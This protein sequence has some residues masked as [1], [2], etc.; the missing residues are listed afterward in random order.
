MKW[1]LLVFSF[2][3]NF[4]IPGNIM[5]HLCFYLLVV[6]HTCVLCLTSPFRFPG[7]SPF[8]SKSEIHI[9]K[10]KVKVFLYSFEYWVNCIKSPLSTIFYIWM[11]RKVN[12]IIMGFQF[13]IQPESK[14][15]REPVISVF[16]LVQSPQEFLPLSSPSLL[17]YCSS[18][19][20][21]TRHPALR[22]VETHSDSGQ[23]EVLLLAATRRHDWRVQGSD[24][25]QDAVQC[26]QTWYN[27]AQ[28][29][30]VTQSGCGATWV[31]EA[32]ERVV[33]GEAAVP[34]EPPVG[35][36]ARQLDG[37]DLGLQRAL[38]ANKTRTRLFRR[39]NN[40][41]WKLLQPLKPLVLRFSA[42]AEQQMVPSK[43]TL[44]T[45]E[46][47]KYRHKMW[48]CNSINSIK[49]NLSRKSS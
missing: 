21:P 6:H 4:P 23:A 20:A 33:G 8:I 36:T 24:T 17:C 46:A 3:E 47:V 12:I 29:C 34:L 38:S 27:R 1:K 31:D 30:W 22:P 48:L 13:S 41:L 14:I 16:I 18:S 49:W 40:F 39:H 11:I 32:E 26:N 15:W 7:F 10:A 44:W 37:Q 2:N 42:H 43:I 25:Q 9:N 19:L 5:I 45:R 35:A 28:R